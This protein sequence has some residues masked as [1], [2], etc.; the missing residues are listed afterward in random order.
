ME[1]NYSFDLKQRETENL[2]EFFEKVQNNLSRR[3]LD[4]SNR[5]VGHIFE[6]VD[7]P[8]GFY[9]EEYSPE[10]SFQVSFSGN[11]TYHFFLRTYSFKN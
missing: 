5:E 3:G 9:N 6:V 8:R 10:Y 2:G 1:K 7:G 11:D 4:L